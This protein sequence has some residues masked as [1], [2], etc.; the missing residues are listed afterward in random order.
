[1]TRNVKMSPRTFYLNEQHELA[2][3]DKE[4]GG[5]I[6]K[7]IDINW[8]TKGAKITRSLESASRQ[9]QQSPDPRKG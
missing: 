9:I 1:M 4:G 8:A 5:S 3:S 2:R 6:P 7:Y